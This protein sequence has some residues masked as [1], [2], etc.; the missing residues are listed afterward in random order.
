MRE[1]TTARRRLKFVDLFAGLGGFHL[2]LSALGHKCIFASEIDKDLR[3]VYKKNFRIDPKGDIRSINEADIPTHDVLCA[4]FPCQ[5]FSKAGEQLGTECKLWGD[6]FTD[7][8]LRIIRHH[9]PSFLIMENVANLERHDGGRTWK[10][11]HLKLES[12]CQYTVDARVLS[13][14]RFGIPQ[15]R[16]RLYIVGSRTGLSHFTWPEPTDKKPSIKKILDRCPEDATELP[17]Q[18][19]RCL[20]VWQ[21]FLDKAPASVEL[22]AFPLWTMEFGATYPFTKY[23]TLKKVPLKKLR[24]FKGSFG[25][26]LNYYHRSDILECLPSYARPAVGAFPYWKQQFIR[27]NR[28][29]YEDNKS[30]I[31]P[32]LPKIREFPSSLQKLEWHCHG[33]ERDIW[34]YVIQFRASGVRV[35][36]ATTAP[37]LVAMT[38]TQVPIIGWEQRYMTPRECARL[39][40]MDQLK[41]LPTALTT[42]HKALGNAVNVEMIR[43]IAENLCIMKAVKG[44]ERAA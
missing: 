6:L 33:E 21:E 31:K 43:Q 1:A 14:H 22:S 3:A 7:H 10:A 42:V 29:F 17:D 32:W 41:H 36:R 5:P 34:K 25:Q 8:V 23:D 24:N 20:D 38:T 40:S 26:S 2:A 12:E 16:D 19:I 11:M 37:S 30:W 15:I 9:R 28:R 35:K 4:G 18:V 44:R 27:N 13:P 39:Q